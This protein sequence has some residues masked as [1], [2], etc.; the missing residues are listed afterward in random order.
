MG[1]RAVWKGPS[2]ALEDETLVRSGHSLV[3]PCMRP[4][5]SIS[6]VT[7]STIAA[8]AVNATRTSGLRRAFPAR[9]ALSR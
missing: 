3:P 4:V 2:M 5:N 6:A 1:Y 8:R 7:M 9:R